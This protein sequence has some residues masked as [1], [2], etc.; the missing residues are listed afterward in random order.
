MTRLEGTGRVGLLHTL[1]S[2][3][4]C[5]L[6]PAN[7]LTE[8]ELKERQE[9]GMADPE[10]QMILTDPVMRQVLNDFQSDPKAAQART[11][12][13]GQRGARRVCVLELTR[14]RLLRARSTTPRT[15]GS[16]PSCRSSST[17]AR[18][19]VTAARLRHTG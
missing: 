10:I 6:P 5:A 7:Q 2:P 11:Q 19:S 9:R 1:G 4:S 3:G 8:E 13:G 15:R 17:Q 12:R 14:A 16:W 18:G